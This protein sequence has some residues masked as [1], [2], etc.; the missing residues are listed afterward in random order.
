MNPTHSGSVEPTPEHMRGIHRR[1]GNTLLDQC[2]GL[3]ESMWMESLNGVLCQVD[4][5][6]PRACESCKRRW[7]RLRE[8]IARY[9][10]GERL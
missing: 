6:D 1:H 2:I 3:M 7:A 8:L 5:E 9:D 10:A 4:D